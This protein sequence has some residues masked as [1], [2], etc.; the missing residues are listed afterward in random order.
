MN[1][2]DKKFFGTILSVG[3]LLIAFS[4][5]ISG[6]VPFIA[7]I[8]LTSAEKMLNIILFG[9]AIVVAYYSLETYRIRIDSSRREEAEL[10]GYLGIVKECSGW[11][12]EKGIVGADFRNYGGTPLYEVDH[13]FIFEHRAT[14][15]GLRMGKITG[16]N[17]LN[18]SQE[19][20]YFG[21]ASKDVMEQGI[22]EYDIVIET[23]YK[24]YTGRRFRHSVRINYSDGENIWIAGENEVE[25]T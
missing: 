6:V 18:P 9:T 1:P 11:D 4:E 21:S 14:G 16:P 22:K 5:A 10:R 13:S 23:E 15:K 20:T 24:T 17:I 12:I 8:D 25:I 7:V 19:R 2:K 3:V